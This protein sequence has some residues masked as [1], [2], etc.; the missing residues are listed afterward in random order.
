[1]NAPT[2]PLNTTGSRVA[3]WKSWAI[4]L[5]LVAA[6]IIH[7]LRHYEIRAYSDPL[8]WLTFARNFGTEIHASKFALGFPIFLRAA[9]ELTGPFNVFLVN[10]P[11]LL[12]LYFLGAGLAARA[13]GPG[14]RIPR[15]Q[16]LT[17]TLALFFAYDPWL[18][19]QMMNPFRD[20]LSF[21]LALAA[22]GCLAKHADTGGARPARAAAAGLLLGL[23]SSVRETSVLLLAPFALY[24]F[25]SWRADAR[26][27]FWR[28]AWWFAAGFS[29]GLAP[30][31]IQG[32]LKTGQA[33]LP[34]QSAV[35]NKLVPGA[36]FTWACMRG[37]LK[38]AWPYLRRAAGPGLLLLAGSAALGLWKRNRIIVGLLLSSALVHAVFYAFYWTFVPRYFYSV[39]VFAMPVAAW[40]L[41]LALRRAAA[42][43]PERFRA[44]TPGAI[45]GA[46]ALGTAAHLLAMR[47][48]EPR[49][50][51]PQARQFAADL[52]PLIPADSLVFSRRHMCEMLQW[53]ASARA[54]PATALIPQD[55]PVEARLREAL[56]PY[57]ADP[58]PLLLMEMSPGSGWEVDAALL[59]RICGLDL[60]ATLPADRYHLGKRTGASDF[61]L[62]RVVDR[63]PPP[64]VLPGIELAQLGTVRFDFALQAV[65]IAAEAL[66]GDFDPPTLARNTPRIRTAATVALPGP[67]GPG[68]TACVEFRLCSLKRGGEPVDVQV[69]CGEATLPIRLRQDR[70]WRI[71]S[72]SVPGP[73]ES[74]ALRFQTTV[75]IDLHWVDWSIPQ[76][77]VRLDVDLGANGDLAHLRTG[78]FDRE[79]SSNGNARW[80][81]PV[82]ALAWRCAAPGTPGRITLRHYAH[83]RPDAA[84][85]P[86]LFCN[87]VE[88]NASDQPD[89]ESGFATLSAEISPGVLKAENDI[90]IESEGWQPGGGDP[91]TLGLFVDWIR[92]EA[93]MP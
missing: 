41:G 40:G 24:A 65:P 43:L 39:A 87:D 19:V 29:A 79:K 78:W 63:S 33:F 35:E 8:N 85:Q 9:L 77:V 47:P 80:T 64:Q 3:A 68:E 72:F 32:W 26:I 58:R 90:R 54:F 93:D 36:H 55:V 45:V 12:A 52:E 30:L 23:A 73:V 2:P 17:L 67:V 37:T 4:P 48:S 88:L 49:F 10:L 57:L 89:D 18:V 27:R 16:I 13:L 81:Q 20:P 14:T 56:T 28:D 46:I 5:A 22:A 15:W 62:F 50:Q 66:T 74:P 61:R 92:F 38:V 11:V 34:P 7:V 70:G 1:M 25:W 71:F 83:N 76:P 69:S 53:F 84:P 75:P 31:L 86:R 60:V 42:W 6:W 82:A 21:L 91:R 51:I 59:N 44:A